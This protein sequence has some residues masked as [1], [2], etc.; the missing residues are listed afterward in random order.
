MQSMLRGPAAGELLPRIVRYLS[1]GHGH[2]HGQAP[3]PPPTLKTQ[4][5]KLYLRVH[6]DLFQLHPEKKAVNERSLAALMSFVDGVMKPA[7]E[8]EGSS[9]P[10]WQDSAARVEFYIRENVGKGGPDPGGGARR[11]AGPP[12]E[13]FRLVSAMLRASGAAD[14]AHGARAPTLGEFLAHAGPA[15]RVKRAEARERERAE[16]F[17]GT[18]LRMVFGDGARLA[19]LRELPVVFAEGPSRLDPRGRVRPPRA[20]PAPPPSPG[21]PGG[22]AGGAGVGEGA[23]AWGAFLRDTDLEAAAATRRALR[24]VAAAARPAPRRA[25]GR[26]AEEGQEEEAARRLG[27]GAVFASDPR[28]EY[29]ALLQALAAGPEPPLPAH[30]PAGEP[31]GRG[32]EG[33][34]TGRGPGRGRAG[35]AGLPLPLRGADR[36]GAAGGGGGAG[37]GGVRAARARRRVE[38]EERLVGRLLDKVRARLRLA[39]LGHEAEAPLLAD[40]A[41]VIGRAY[42]VTEEGKLVIPHSFDV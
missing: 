42:G 6:P 30:G 17:V 15:A 29:A 32:G 25:P 5:K 3:Q 33:R 1:S 11:P 19:A 24:L 18:S 13:R 4:L 28:L 9:G 26:G 10:A 2:A 41:L 16:H 8:K 34:E 22:A 38:G 7:G 14:F 31:E 27:L 23:E 21:G 37:R 20:P 35:A 39:S 36:D 12:E 40:H